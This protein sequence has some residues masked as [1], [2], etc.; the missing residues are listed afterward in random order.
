MIA[1]VVSELTYTNLKFAKTTT[2][3]VKQTSF[4]CIIL[5]GL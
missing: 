5:K 2:F 1:F 3:Y 4:E